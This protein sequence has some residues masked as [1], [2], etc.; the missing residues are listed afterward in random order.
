MTEQPGRLAAYWER[1]LD[2]LDEKE[3]RRARQLPGWRTRKHRRTLVVVLVLADLALIA[4]A[5]RFK[6][7]PDWLFAV[8][9][10]S[11][12]VVGGFAFITL[13]VLTGRINAGFSRL[14]DERER[15]WRHRVTYIGYQTL[16]YLMV[17]ALVY[18]LIIA[19]TEDG[20]VRGAMMLSALLVT[21]T[22]ISSIVLGWSL[23]DDDPEDF[24]EGM[25][26]A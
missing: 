13:R 2:K 12:L 6:V 1:Q 7:T 5:A 17:I 15:E 4:G 16:S 11:G 8:F 18:G 3:R 25:D 19:N 21:G 22:T 9:W 10:L 14:L 24:E 20:G 26:H 23:P